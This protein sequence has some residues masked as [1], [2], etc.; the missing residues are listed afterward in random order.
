[1]S[2][3]APTTSVF[4]SADQG[5]TVKASPLFDIVHP[6]LCLSAPSPATFQG[7]LEDC[8]GQAVVA[9]DVAEPRQFP[10]LHNCKKG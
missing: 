7:P 3:A 1:M 6:G 5:W 4:G 8:F 2:Q 10:P 9:S